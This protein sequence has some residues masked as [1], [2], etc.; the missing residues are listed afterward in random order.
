MTGDTPPNLRP[1]DTPPFWSLTPGWEECP[2]IR[3]LGGGNVPFLIIICLRR[4][5]NGKRTGFGA[6]KNEC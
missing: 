6:C 1:G 5:T 3:L 2:N 4:N